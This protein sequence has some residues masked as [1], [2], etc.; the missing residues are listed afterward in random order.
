[1][2]ARTIE[3]QIGNFSRELHEI[4]DSVVATLTGAMCGC[5]DRQEAHVMAVKRIDRDLTMKELALE[6]RCFA[7]LAVEE[8]GEIDLRTMIS[9]I[10]IK[11]DLKR[12]NDL[13]LHIL[14][15][16]PDLSAELFESFEFDRIGNL[17]LSMIEKSIDSFFSKNLGNTPEVLALDEQIHERL[18]R[19]FSI[20]N[21]L[22]SNTRIAP[23]QLLSALSISRHIGLITDHAENIAFTAHYLVTGRIDPKHLSFDRHPGVS[24]ATGNN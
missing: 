9:I 12:I 5:A 14:E 17:M 7:F 1:M 10:K 24:F 22:M 2:P 6:E 13:T 19:V 3:E 21:A 4:A 16:I 18:H 11:E 20:A 15:K 23:D 8:P